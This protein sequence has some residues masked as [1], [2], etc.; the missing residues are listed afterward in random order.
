MY[1]LNKNFKQNEMVR[2]KK[3]ADERLVGTIGVIIGRERYTSA[4]MHNDGFDYIIL[5]EQ[6]PIG[7]QWKAQMLHESCLERL[8]K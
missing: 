4:A 5:L 6:Q 3:H 2:I 7:V 8:E 1:L